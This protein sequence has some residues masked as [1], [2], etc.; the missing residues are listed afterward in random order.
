MKFV[1]VFAIFTILFINLHTTI[2]A[3]SPG[4][5]R[6]DGNITFYWKENAEDRKGQMRN[7]GKSEETF[8]KNKYSELP[9]E[10][11]PKYI[12]AYQVLGDCC[13]K[14]YGKP[15]FSGESKKLKNLDFQT[16]GFRGIPGYPQLQVNSLKK[17]PCPKKK[18]EKTR[19][20]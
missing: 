15:N 14:I 9:I 18:V 13:W 3:A 11:D 8:E 1:P 4:N 10:V 2:Y 7:W 16:F 12:Y 19:K 6:G 20:I 17:I 5:F